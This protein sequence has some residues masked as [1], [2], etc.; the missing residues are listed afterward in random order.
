MNKRLITSWLHVFMVIALLAIFYAVFEGL[1]FYSGGN[2]H[3]AGIAATVIMLIVLLLFFIPQQLKGHDGNFNK[4]IILERYFVLLLAPFSLIGTAF[5]ISHFLSIQRN[6]PLITQ[7]F[8]CAIDTAKNMFEEYEKYANE[9]ISRYNYHL[10]HTSKMD[11]ESK[12]KALRLQLL[13]AN[14]DTLHTSAKEWIETYAKEPSTLNVFVLGNIEGIKQAIVSWNTQLQELSSKRMSDEPD[15][16]EAFANPSECTIAATA[17]FDD[18]GHLYRQ[19]QPFSI[20]DFLAMLL[21]WFFLM[22]PYFFQ[23]RHSKSTMRLFGKKKRNHS[24]SIFMEDKDTKR[25]S[26]RF[27]LNKKK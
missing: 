5:F 21:L 1:S 11:R 15:G 16:S 2:F 17:I 22:L 13:S 10:R 23:Q 20:W 8:T 26:F 18:L 3:L 14:Y 12:D 19:R 9:R 24:N 27:K 6:E 7:Q 25:Q 4:M